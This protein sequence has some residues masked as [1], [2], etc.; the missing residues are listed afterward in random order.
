M[1]RVA[2]SG[3]DE[4][5]RWTY[6]KA[7]DQD[8]TEWRIIPW[9]YFRQHVVLRHPDAKV[10]A[11]IAK[12]AKAAAANN[13]IGY[14]QMQRTTFW[15]ELARAGYDPS[16]IQTPCEAD[17][18]AGVAAIVKAVGYR[19][20][21]RKLQA[22]SSECWTGNLRSALM[23]AGFQ[24]LYGSAYCETGK[25]LI[26]GDINLNEAQH[27]NI[28]VEGDGA[29]PDTG[30][31]DTDGL[32]GSATTRKLQQVYGTYVDGEVWHQWAPNKQPW[33]TLGWKYDDSGEGSPLI[34]SMQKHLGTGDADGLAGTIFWRALMKKTKTSNGFAAVEEMQRRL[35]AGKWK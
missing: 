27:T 3:H 33:C 31:L 16:R 7:G 30:K 4:N 22:V 1:T 26:P 15:R 19:L 24:A 20:G 2:N 14:D 25:N 29:T 32:W 18:S 12:L 10:R 6:G 9:Y 5:G 21:N 11:E 34:R 8:G 17:C 23:G 13:N 28:V 35:N